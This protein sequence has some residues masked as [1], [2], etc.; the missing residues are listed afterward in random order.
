ALNGPAQFREAEALAD[1]AAFRKNPI[2]QGQQFPRE[3]KLGVRL[4]IQA[5][6]EGYFDQFCHERQ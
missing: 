4:Q 5:A 2:L 3:N 6:F 1:Y